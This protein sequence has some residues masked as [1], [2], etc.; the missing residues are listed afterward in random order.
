L[1]YTDYFLWIA[2]DSWGTKKESIG[3]Y[4]QVAESA[5]TFAPKFYEIKGKNL[6][7][8]EI[9]FLRDIPRENRAIIKIDFQIMSF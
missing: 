5:I 1:N 9:L 3:S 6:N 7:H 8:F 2:S 4:E